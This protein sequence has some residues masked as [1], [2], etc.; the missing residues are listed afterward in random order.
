[1]KTAR[2]GDYLAFPWG[3]RGGT[4]ILRG[5]RQ[6]GQGWREVMTEAED[7]VMSAKERE[8]LLT[9]GNGKEQRAP[10]NLQKASLADI[11]TLGQLVSRD[12]KQ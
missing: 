11:L 9:A 3:P 12:V 6:E 4:E 7:R 5:G 10:P 2:L 8:H 1:M